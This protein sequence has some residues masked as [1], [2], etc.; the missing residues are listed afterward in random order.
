MKYIVES[1]AGLILN[2]APS[3]DG[4]MMIRVDGF[5][6]IKI[7][8]TLARKISKGLEERNLTVRIKLAKNKWKYFQ[9]NSDESSYLQSMVQ[10]GWV[11]E[12]KSITDYRNMH[13]K[14][15]LV[16]MGTENE[17]DKGGFNNFYTITPD[18]LVSELAEDYYGL[19]SRVI[20]FSQED[21]DVVNKL[22]KD[23]FEYVAIDICKLSDLIDG[24]EGRISTINDFIELFYAS[25]P[26]WGLP[27]KKLDL[28]TAK[29]LKGKNN[30]LK[31]EYNFISRQLFKKLSKPQYAKY[32]EQL[33]KYEK[34]RHEYSSVWDGW[35]AQGI[36]SYSAFADIVMGYIRGENVS[37]YR[38]KLINTDFS[39]VEAV[40]DIKIVREKKQ[41]TTIPVVVGDPIEAF[42]SALLQMLK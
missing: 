5:E 20:D 21:I 14:N 36:N 23:L 33:E 9:N 30:I 2:N 18:V 10:N 37:E 7:Y 19:F 32:K 22:Y 6:D 31:T 16:L 35:S 34:D 27:Y 38:D 17:E 41:R 24:W 1:I 8:E 4:E 26:E 39:I 13:D 29:Q 11:I 40:L 25:L 3:A 42:T 12:N 28:P 15:V